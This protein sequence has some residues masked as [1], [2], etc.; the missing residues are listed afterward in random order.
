MSLSS[1]C[2]G[3][4]SYRFSSIT[5]LILSKP[6]HISAKD[7]VER[8]KAEAKVIW[9]AEVGDD[10]HLFDEGAVDAVAF[11]VADADVRAANGRVQ[12]ESRGKSQ[13]GR[14]SFP[15]R[16]RRSPSSKWIWRGCASMPA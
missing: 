1:F 2:F 11:G 5:R 16:K 15:L 9:G 4:F 6:S 14:A 7:S 8:R 13:R 3:Y 12:L 10:V